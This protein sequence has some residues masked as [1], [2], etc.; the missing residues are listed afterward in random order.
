[1]NKTSACLRRSKITERQEWGEL[2]W[3]LLCGVMCA[4]IGV[5]RVVWE[6]PRG[7]LN[8]DPLDWGKFHRGDYPSLWDSQGELKMAC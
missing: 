8:L 6:H 3:Q 4:R 5:S 1:M 7:A 2:T